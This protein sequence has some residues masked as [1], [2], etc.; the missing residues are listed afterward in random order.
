MENA[1]ET[2]FEWFDYVIRFFFQSPLFFAQD[3]LPSDWFVEQKFTRLYFRLVNKILDCNWKCD[4]FQ[5]IEIFGTVAF[6]DT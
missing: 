5:T 4:T 3:C 2:I 6:T 1:Y